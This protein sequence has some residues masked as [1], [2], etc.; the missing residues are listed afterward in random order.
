MSVDLSG[1]K[2]GDLVIRI[3][4]GV[5]EMRMVVYS[6]GG[7]SLFCF[8]EDLGKVDLWEFDLG[9]GAEIDD[10]LNWGPKYGATGSFLVKVEKSH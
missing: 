4:G 1:V 6:V 2:P 3:L 10:F 7:S 9:T 8:P 5:S